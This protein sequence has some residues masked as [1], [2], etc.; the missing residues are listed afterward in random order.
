MKRIE[1]ANNTIVEIPNGPIGISCSGGTDSSLLLYILM[2]NTTSPIH[3][4]T[5]SNNKKGRANAVVVP[6]VIEQCIQLT[7]NINLVHHS[8]YAEDQTEAS[9]FDIQRNYLKDKTIECIFS[10]IT[11]NP[12]ADVLPSDETDRDPTVKKSETD[13]NGFL[14]RPFVNKDKQTIAQ[15]YKDLDLM[16]K[17]FPATRSCEQVGKLEYYDHCGECWW[18]YERQWGFGSV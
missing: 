16:N 9:L 10:G 4:F 5:L 1:L 15:I 14:R 6:R 12:P 7:G 13:Y 2:S 11:A 17:L 3:I 18:C 8:Y